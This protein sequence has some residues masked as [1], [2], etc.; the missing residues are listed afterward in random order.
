MKLQQYD[1]K[2]AAYQRLKKKQA[3]QNVFDFP[4]FIEMRPVIRAAVVWKN[5]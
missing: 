4:D 1:F 2:N 5:N 3:F